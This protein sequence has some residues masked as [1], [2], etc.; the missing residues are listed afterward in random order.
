MRAAKSV[1]CFCVSEPQKRSKTENA[2]R[3]RKIGKRPCLRQTHANIYI[4]DI[5]AFASVRRL[6]A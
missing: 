4:Y 5:Y 2:F 1:F 6:R 3:S